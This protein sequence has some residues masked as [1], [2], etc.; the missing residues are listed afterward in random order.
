MQWQASRQIL[1]A[2]REHWQFGPIDL[3]LQAWGEPASIEN[4]RTA[5][6]SRFQTVLPELVDELV[7]LRLPVGRHLRVNG[8]VAQRMLAACRPFAADF[9]TPMAAVAGSVADEICGF[10]TREPGVRRAYVNNGGDIA[11]HL[12]E[13]ESVTIGVIDHPQRPRQVGDVTITSDMPVRGVA[14][15]GWRGRSF[16]LGIADSVTVLA[17][18][19][20]A[21]DAAATMVANAVNIGH[22]AIR[23]VPANTVKDDSD[24]GARMV[25]V[26]VALLPTAAVHSALDAGA[27]FAQ[28]CI[29]SGSVHSALLLLQGETRAI[30][31]QSWLGRL[32][33][34][35][36]G[37]AGMGALPQ[38]LPVRLAA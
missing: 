14:T 3:V 37:R 10:Y 32:C 17:A 11:L 4:A 12:C 15:S 19:A 9:I 36:I 6:W 25:T 23:R 13:G 16:S 18:N 5:A 34:A 24:L 20:A 35:Q 2:G 7:Q 26:E 33:P 8:A 31:A 38:A 21:A 29:G 1:D 30:G 27:T 28:A 22:P